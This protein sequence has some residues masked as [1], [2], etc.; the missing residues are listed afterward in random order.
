MPAYARWLALLLLGALSCTQCEDASEP[1][2]KTSA[3][4]QPGREREWP[5]ELAQRFAAAAEPTPA[6]A[7]VQEP[8]DLPRIQK[9]GTLRVLVESTGESYLP[10]TGSGGLDERALLTD[11]A[12]RLGLEPEFI[13]LE[14]FDELLPALKAGE[15]DVI[16]AAV[17]VTPARKDEVAFTWPL[18]TVAEV[19][20]GREGAQDLPKNVKEL[21]GREVH[22][23]AGSSFAQSLEALRTSGVE[24]KIVPAPEASDPEAL[25]HEVTRGARPL[26][27]VDSHMLKSVQA[28][29]PDAVALFEIATGREIAWAV[30]KDAKALLARL[31]AFVIER[32]LTEHTEKRFVGD[33]AGIKKRGELRVLTRNNPITYFM[34]RGQPFG[35]DYELMKMFAERLGV[36]LTMVV[37]PSRSELIPW[38]IEGRGDII[39][40]SMTVTPER[41]KQVAFSRPYLFVDEVL[42]QRKAGPKLASLEALR[43]Q[44]VHVRKSSSYFETLTR[45]QDR[46]GPF[47]IILADEHDETEELIR[48]VAEGEIP[49]T[50]A[51][52]HIV[53]VELAWRDDIEP[54]FAL[55]PASSADAGT[56]AEQGQNELA[57]AVRKENP[58]L[59]ALLDRFVKEEYRG[60]CYNMAK[61]R[62][63]KNA[64][65]IAEAKEERLEV[66]GRI[67]KYDALIQKYA[68]KYGLDWRLLA[69]QAYQESRFDPEAKSWV[70]AEGL[71]Q[72]MPATGKE[73][74]FTRLRDPEEGV[75]AGV[76]YMHKLIRRYDSNIPFKQRV[77][78]ALASYNAGYGH[79][80]DARRL[81]RAKGW[82]PDRWFGNVEKAMLLLERPQF[83]KH[84]RYGYCRGSEP[85]KYV[86]EIQLRYDQYVELVD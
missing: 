75:H 64:R 32:V 77:R 10:R 52:S 36:R 37:P 41:R 76:R 61:N 60:L 25:V 50:V 15:G 12:D 57:F 16:A 9:R 26:T 62:Y 42:V 33:L 18:E 55:A 66:T 78:F 53:D 65:R 38:L 40:A 70:G 72:V 4:A 47:E 59:L 22:V 3:S 67:S 7:R 80:E 48:K 14:T 8:W 71:F 79:V 83:Y 43:D 86:S 73:M 45:L 20:V 6:K 5:D 13:Y 44:R 69:A 21:A 17:T 63:F 39:A 34:Y 84:A 35:F 56:G 29:N 68:V 1:V 2:E 49:Y 28:Y 74:G 58:K 46:A 27:V 30:R 81:A 31:N 82:D 85:V 23:R 19:L 11:F 24:V 54:A 51:D